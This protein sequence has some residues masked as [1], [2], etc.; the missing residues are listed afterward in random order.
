MKYVS[1]FANKTEGWILACV[2]DNE[3]GPK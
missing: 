1:K 3:E 2:E